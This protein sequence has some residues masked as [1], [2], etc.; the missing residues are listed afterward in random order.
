VTLTFDRE[1]TAFCAVVQFYPKVLLK[2]QAIQQ[3]G[4]T[5]CDS[6]LLLLRSDIY[7]QIHFTKTVPSNNQSRTFTLLYFSYN[8]FM[9]SV[10]SAYNY[11]NVDNA[12]YRLEQ[13]A[14]TVDWVTR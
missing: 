9:F 11:I 10:Q 8:T 7:H 4:H 2:F 6:F 1:F 14:H 3:F 13:N 5:I 12:K